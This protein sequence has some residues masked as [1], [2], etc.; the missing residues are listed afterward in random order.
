VARTIAALL[1]VAPAATS[2]SYGRVVKEAFKGGPNA[3]LHLH[4]PLSESLNLR[5][6]RVST[7]IDTERMDG[8]IYPAGSTVKSTSMG[9]VNQHR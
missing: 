8:E 3:R 4:V 9:D 7:T 6:R 5:D 2:G 1:S